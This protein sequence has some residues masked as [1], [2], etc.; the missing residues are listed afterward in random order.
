M[1]PGFT[2][3][4]NVL[5]VFHYPSVLFNYTQLAKSKRIWI[6]CWYAVLFL[7]LGTVAEGGNPSKP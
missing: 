6:L 1:C 5:T 4:F 3:D 2:A 7:E